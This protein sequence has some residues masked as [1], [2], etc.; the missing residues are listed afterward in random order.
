MT[1]T[2]AQLPLDRWLVV[3]PLAS[4]E[5]KLISTHEAQCEAETERDKRNK[6]QGRQRYVAI[7]TLA[8]VAAGAQGCAA[9]LVMSGK[10]H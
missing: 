6:G 2:F 10:G 3:E 9:M 8:P 1:M 5:V 4:N 7:K